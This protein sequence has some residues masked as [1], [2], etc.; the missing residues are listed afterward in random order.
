MDLDERDLR[1]IRGAPKTCHII[2]TDGPLPLML[3]ASHRARH[4]K[5]TNFNGYCVVTRL[6]NEIGSYPAALLALARLN[7]IRLTELGGA[8]CIKEE[9]RQQLAELWKQHRDRPRIRSFTPLSRR[10]RRGV[11][12][13]D[14]SPVEPQLVL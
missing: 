11:W 4:L 1:G 10:S 8:W 9:D 6:A 13:G 3:T 12:Q 14:G 2:Y 7:R 5:V